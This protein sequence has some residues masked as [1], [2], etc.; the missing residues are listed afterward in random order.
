MLETSYN[1]AVEHKQK[2][3][4]TLRPTLRVG[5]DCTGARPLLFVNDHHIACLNPLALAQKL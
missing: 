1:F 4:V 5:F 3:E 2:V